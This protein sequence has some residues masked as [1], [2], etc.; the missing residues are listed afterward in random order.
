MNISAAKKGGN[1]VKDALHDSPLIPVSLNPEVLYYGEGG[2]R[3]SCNVSCVNGVARFHEVGAF[4][5]VVWG[6]F[7][8]RNSKS[9]RIL[10]FKSRDDWPHKGVVLREIS[11]LPDGEHA[12]VENGLSGHGFPYLCWAEEDVSGRVSWSEPFDV[13]KR[14][15]NWDELMSY[16]NEVVVEEQRIPEGESSYRQ[17]WFGEKGEVLYERPAAKSGDD[18]IANPPPFMPT[19]ILL[20]G[21]STG[22]GGR[23]A[24]ELANLQ[25]IN[26]T[27]T[28]Q[29]FAVYDPSVT[30]AV[31][32]QIAADKRQDNIDYNNW[33]AQHPGECPRTY[34][35]TP[36]MGLIGS[37]LGSPPEVE[38]ATFPDSYERCGP[39][40]QGPCYDAGAGADIIA[41]SSP[42]EDLPIYLIPA[43]TQSEVA[44]LRTSAA[45][46]ENPADP[47][48]AHTRAI[49]LLGDR[50]YD[51]IDPAVGEAVENLE[52]ACEA[53]GIPAYSLRSSAY[54]AGVFPPRKAEFVA[55]V[56]AGV[57]LI[58]GTGGPT[59]KRKWPG[60][61][62]WGLNWEAELTTPQTVVVLLPNCDT[63]AEQM[64]VQGATSLIKEGLFASPSGTTIGFALGHMRGGYD[65]QH[66]LWL[67]IIGLAYADA[68][69]GTP[70]PKIIFDAKYR[71]VAQYPFLEDYLRSALP[72][73]T[74]I[75]KRPPPTTSD[76]GGQDVA[77]GL[78]KLLGLRIVRNGSD[79]PTFELALPRSDDA[80]LTVYDA[81]GRIMATVYNQRAEAGRSFVTWNGRDK[82]GKSVGSG[83]YFARLFTRSNGIARTKAIIVR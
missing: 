9:V 5:N 61:Y 49:F 74:M 40:I 71:A 2:W 75:R 46:Y 32:Q 4:G 13:T 19:D 16:G 83:V 20:L 77:A 25:A 21:K 39:I 8:H 56:N 70:W 48:W 33:C 63:A 35:E 43:S 6:L 1:R 18:Q 38:F 62:T 45:R 76:A 24:T 59:E 15:E 81:R 29:T 55:A 41:G 36:V 12:Y 3:L 22:D 80:T 51:G 26:P 44:N 73:G 52:S 23:L 11:P 57:S 34:P 37:P 65:H 68:P 58:A 14:P 53:Q 17:V 10:G 7:A 66:A 79:G 69:V 28:V 50:Y 72:L 27:W 64:T 67:E 78:P 30:V 54:P 60:E 42:L 31:Q 47:S 82:N